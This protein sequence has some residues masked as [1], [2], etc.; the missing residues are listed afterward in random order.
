[1]QAA[2]GKTTIDKGL[3]NIAVSLAIITLFVISPVSSVINL[4]LSGLLP[5]DTPYYLR[6]MTSFFITYGSL[7]WVY[8]LIVKHTRLNHWLKPSRNIHITMGIGNFIYLAYY[9][10][11]I[12]ILAIL[13]N[14]SS[15][16]VFKQRFYFTFPAYILIFGGWLQLLVRS[17]KLSKAKPAITEDSIQ[18]DAEK[19]VDDVTDKFPTQENNINVVM[20]AVFFLAFIIPFALFGSKYASELLPFGYM[21]NVKEL[22][23]ENCKTAGQTINRK[24]NNDIKSLYIEAGFSNYGKI[25]GGHYRS[26]GG[27]SV[28]AGHLSLDFIEKPN[29]SSKKSYKYRRYYPGDYKGTPVDELKSRYGVLF[30]KDSLPKDAYR[31]YG[32]NGGTINAVDLDTDEVLATT[33]YFSSKHGHKFCGHT[34]G[35]N[36][37]T[38]AFVREVFNI[39]RI[40]AGRPITYH[41]QHD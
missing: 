35:G 41:N 8:Y 2:P 5:K 6:Y 20:A 22:Y 1:M 10:G 4:L 38:Q 37:S 7:I 31:I 16:F 27:G 12:F 9:I 13:D 11:V 25:K 24:V 14:A 21:H 33:T 17:K 28:N 40:I 18:P 29:P 3:V 23:N 30:D 15:Y 19:S 34:P 26:V 39:K 36:F 32:I